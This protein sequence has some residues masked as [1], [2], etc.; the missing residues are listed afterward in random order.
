MDGLISR[1]RRFSQRV[2]VCQVLKVKEMGFNGVLS[3]RSGAMKVGGE[4]SFSGEV[5]FHRSVSV[6]R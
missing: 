1:G 4:S 3:V 6:G 5:G 2:C